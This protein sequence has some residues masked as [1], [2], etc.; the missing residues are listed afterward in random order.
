[1]SSLDTSNRLK[2]LEAQL[3]SKLAI[4]GGLLAKTSGDVESGAGSVPGGLEERSLSTDIDNDLSEMNK[5]ISLMRNDGDSTSRHDFVLRRF[6]NVYSDY[7]AEY[8]KLSS[9]L[10][11]ARDTSDLFQYKDG[12]GRN[13]TA[14]GGSGSNENSS[15]TD[16]LLRERSGI[17]S[18]LK[19]VNEVISQAYEAKDSLFSQR[20]SLGGAQQGLMGMVRAVPTFNRLISAVSKK[21][22][23]ENLIIAAFVSVLAIFTIWWVFMR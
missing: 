8:A 14:I 19:G 13:Q 10:Q 17:A 1:M 20:S 6:E 22:D 16:K 12:Q 4:F 11:K 18:S 9:R 21:K 3:E 23:R 15:A 2:T 7:C 5:N